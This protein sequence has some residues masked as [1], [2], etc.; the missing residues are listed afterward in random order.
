MRLHEP[1]DTDELERLKAMAVADVA[2]L[3][4]STQKR[5]QV[6]NDAAGVPLPAWRLARG[7]YDADKVRAGQRAAADRRVERRREAELRIRNR[8]D[9]NP[10]SARSPHIR[11]RVVSVTT[12]KN[13]CRKS[14][15]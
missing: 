6:A 2:V 11:A 5:L 14:N 8:Q 13:S 3:I 7:L 15:T 4:A 9:A 1:V 10:R 12:E